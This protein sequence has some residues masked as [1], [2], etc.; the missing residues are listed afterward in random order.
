MNNHQIK[1]VCNELNIGSDC[2]INDLSQAY[3]IRL[4]KL[5]E[6]K[7]LLIET[8]LKKEI[9]SNIKRLVEIKSYRGL[10]SIRRKSAFRK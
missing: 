4:L 10:K 9:Q 1:N 3:I 7:N 2:R 6:K 8:S 5:L